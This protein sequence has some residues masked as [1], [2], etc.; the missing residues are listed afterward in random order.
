MIKQSVV[1]RFLVFM[2]MYWS[3][4]SV[5]AF[6]KPEANTVFWKVEKVGQAASYLLGTV[7]FG[8]RSDVLPLEAA[9]AFKRSE[10]LI[11]EANIY[12]LNGSHANMRLLAQ[13]YQALNGNALT[14]FGPDRLN[15]V[16]QALSK[17]NTIV[18]PLA[19]MAPWLVN[20]TLN[21]GIFPS[22]YSANYGVDNQLIAQA[23]LQKKPLASLEGVMETI[24]YVQRVP[25]DYW[26]YSVDGILSEQNNIPKIAR[27][28]H[29][30]YQSNQPVA[31]LQYLKKSEQALQK[32]YPKKVKAYFEDYMKSVLIQERNHN[33]MKVLPTMLMEKPSFVAVGTLH[34]YGK[35]G[36][37][38]LL[39]KQGF[40]VTPVFY[41]AMSH[42]PK[43]SKASVL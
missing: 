33:W 1:M 41:D 23:R 30:L 13:Y 17:N 18:M 28:I 40:V 19:T 8:Q 24:A 38:V 27:K 29:H 10:Q 7:H 4:G 15:Q 25:E 37:I 26:V 39:R 12:D 21:Y 36:L 5:W 14:V 34:L 2:L 9:Q 22:E 16:E 31:L 32:H 11:L 35:E 43:P 3:L 20:E 6:E 42:Q